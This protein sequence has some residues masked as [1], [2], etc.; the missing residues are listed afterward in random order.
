[1][2]FIVFV[3]QSLLFEIPSYLLL[4]NSRQTKQEQ[5]IGH[6]LKGALVFSRAKPTILPEPHPVCFCSALVSGKNPLS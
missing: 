1:M 5:D 3:H 6:L 4:V 2:D